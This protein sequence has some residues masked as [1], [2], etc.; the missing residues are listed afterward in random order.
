[1]PAKNILLT[2]ATGFLGS[3]LLEA[4]IADGY[5]VVV[6]K[7]STSDSWRINHLL[8]S[9]ISYDVD[10]IPIETAFVKNK[11]EYVVH[12]AC[13]YGRESESIHEIVET[14]VAFGLK[15]L[16]FCTKY[17]IQTFINTDTLLPKDLNEYSLSKK[18]FVEWMRQYS[19]RLQVLNLKL[20][21]MYGP[22]D[23]STKFIPW[24]VT[25]LKQNVSE[26]KLTLGEQKRDFIHVKDVVSAFITTI[27]NAQQLNSFIEFDVGTGQ[28]VTVKAFITQIK[29]LLEEQKGHSI[30]TFLNFGAI[31]YREREM[32]TVNVDINPLSR[33][34]WR[35]NVSTKK[36]I[37][38]LIN[39]NE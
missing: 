36:G 28:L 6:L 11:I 20:E 35:A 29:N 15:L 39:I 3:H 19:D 7:R 37:Y 4:F 30:D 9:F 27:N 2:G 38:E 13:N 34:G 17:N 5:S 32:M 24:V 14:N 10:L 25:Q 22:K 18:Q 26:I 16:D 21:H 31:P 33:L 23:E 12:T 1:M 8:E